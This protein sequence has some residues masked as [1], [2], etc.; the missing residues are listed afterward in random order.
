MRHTITISYTTDNEQV[1]EDIYNI[2][3]SCLP[4]MAD[5]IDCHLV[6]ED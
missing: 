2:I 5:N 4:Y 3:T 1:K 6:E